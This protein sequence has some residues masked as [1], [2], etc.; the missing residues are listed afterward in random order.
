M[1]ALGWMTRR[2]SAPATGPSGKA[3]SLFSGSIDELHDG[4]F[5][6]PL[7]EVRKHYASLFRC[8]TDD[9]W[10]VAKRSPPVPPRRRV[11]MSGC[12]IRWISIQNARISCVGLI[13]PLAATAPAWPRA[14]RF[15]PLPTAVRVGQ[16]PGSGHGTRGTD[17]Y[18]TTCGRG[19]DR[20]ARLHPQCGRD[21]NT[22]ASTWYSGERSLPVI[23]GSDDRVPRDHGQSQ[24]DAP[25]CKFWGHAGTVSHRQP[26]SATR[27]SC[28]TGH[29]WMADARHRADAAAR[30]ATIG[31][32]GVRGR[33]RP[34]TTRS[35]FR[36]E[37]R[38]GQ[39]RLRRRT[40]PSPGST[41]FVAVAN[42]A[43]RNRDATREIFAPSGRLASV[44]PRRYSSSLA[45]ALSSRSQIMRILRPDPVLCRTLSPGLTTA[46]H[47][48]TDHECCVDCRDTSLHTYGSRVPDSMFG[49][50]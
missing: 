44:S 43:R 31:V 20:N 23:G 33:A 12:R 21:R 25:R 46:D 14:F 2:T 41:A 16:P 1:L 29:P 50:R 30:I 3:R 6:T 40:S 24:C 22:S 5:D 37:P 27:G 4:S 49:R 18:T 42:C 15:Q 8:S 7:R 10:R 28:R 32:P 13:F 38:A 47:D 45:R 35:S 19:D 17:T 26:L 36:C 34:M 9:V 39:P 11:A 48:W